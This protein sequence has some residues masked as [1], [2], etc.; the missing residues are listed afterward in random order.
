ME[1]EIKK[2]LASFRIKPKGALCVPM[3]R[4]LLNLV[5]DVITFLNLVTGGN[6]DWENMQAF[7]FQCCLVSDWEF[8][9]AYEWDEYVQFIMSFSLR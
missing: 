3:F 8:I 5:W 7:A 2:N 6:S 1:Q 4:C 9:Q